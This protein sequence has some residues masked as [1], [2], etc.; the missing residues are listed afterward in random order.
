MKRLYSKY[1]RN[2]IRFAAII[3]LLTGT[4][5]VVRA[6]DFPVYEDLSLSRPACFP[7]FSGNDFKVDKERL[8]LYPDGFLGGDRQTLQL[9]CDYLLNDPAGR[10]MWESQA[11]SAAKILNQWNFNTPNF[12]RYIYAVPQL[13]AL[14][15]T[16]ML[17]G[18][19]E[20]G[21]FIRG[22]V[23][24][25]A[26]L[27]FEFWVHAELRGYNPAK[28]VGGLETAS[29]CTTLG[30]VLSATPDLFAAGEKAKINA[31]LNEKG[32]TPCLNWLAAN[33]SK[34]NNWMAVLSTGAYISA[35]YLNDRQAMNTAVSCIGT[36][37][38]G[39]IEPDGSYG[40]GL[41]YFSYPIQ[42]LLPA[43]LAMTPEEKTTYLSTSNLR[44]SA[45]W[46]VYPMLFSSKPANRSLALHF[47]D[48]SYNAS[49]NSRIITILACIYRD[50]L[51]LWLKNKYR[52]SNSFEEMLLTFSTASG[53]PAPQSLQEA[54]LPTVKAFSAGDSYIRSGWEDDAIVLGMWSGNGS[55]VKYA[56]QRPEMGSICMGAYGEYLIVSAGSASYRAALH[57]DYDRTYKAMNSISID[58]KNQLFPGNGN[59]G[60]VSVDIS[61]YWSSG[62]P[63]AEILQCRSNEM[64]GLLVN[65]MSRSYHVPMKHVRRSVLFVRDPGYFVMVD[66]I[67][68]NG[69]SHQYSWR[70]HLNNK[71][72][73]GKLE[74]KSAGHWLFQRPSVNLDI[75][76][77]SDRE[78]TT[79]IGEGYLHGPGRDYSPGGV[80]E[81]KPGSSIEIE[82]HN[83]QNSQSQLYYSIIYPTKAG[84]SALAVHY[85][86]NTVT[87]GKD[88]ITFSEGACTISKDGK[89]EKYTLW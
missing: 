75:Y 29:V 73:A 30:F 4:M 65:E 40:E 77:Y 89:T 21:L 48:N 58:N 1:L 3:G 60:W 86:A 49:F 62:T 32:L 80:N 26:E 87:V 55:L 63:V 67:E 37:V 18:H 39:S 7:Q 57:Y 82:A 64:T 44:H 76:L 17:S 71:D 41:G 78:I 46:R 68:S 6:A 50:P 59:N 42:T 28:P 14:S 5:N 54:G 33:S 74:E 56:H 22:H 72:N 70:I 36:Y 38:N 69:S 79:A 13:Q 85:A 61:S 66:K 45:A 34:T 84:T 43:M 20:L 35:K 2:V 53:M 25:I 31:V 24:Q 8:D 10:S 88:V 83:R 16:Y 15:Q 19:K 9:L 12:N 47:A 51:A 81:G 52:T 23:L 11:K 27:P